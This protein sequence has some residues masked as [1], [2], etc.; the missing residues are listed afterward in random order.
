MEICPKGVFMKNIILF[1]TLA[2]FPVYAQDK[3]E[4]PKPII[5]AQVYF[6]HWDGH[7][8]IKMSGHLYRI[9]WLVHSD[10]CDCAYFCD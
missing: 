2:T 4:T 6:D 7:Y 8:Y 9:N 5:S 1:F 10:E 3:E